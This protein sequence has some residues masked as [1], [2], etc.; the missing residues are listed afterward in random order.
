MSLQKIPL[1]NSPNQNFQCALTIGNEN[2]NL[3]FLLCYNQIAEYWVISITDTNT[4]ELLLDS[5]SFVTGQYPAGNIL[6][7]YS[8]LDIGSAFL[9]NVSGSSMDYPDDTNL[10][11]DFVLLWGDTL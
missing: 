4:G 2:R 11:A 9:V 8:Y 7:P 6:E 3:S 5:V 1:D 10:G